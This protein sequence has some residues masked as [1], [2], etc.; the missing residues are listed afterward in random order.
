MSQGMIGDAGGSYYAEVSGTSGSTISIDL[1]S[2]NANTG[3]E[4]CGVLVTIQ[5]AFNGNGGCIPSMLVYGGTT[6]GFNGDGLMICRSSVRASGQNESGGTGAEQFDLS[7]TNV[8]SLGFFSYVFIGGLKFGFKSAT[9][10]S[11][12]TSAFTTSSTK[13]HMCGVANTTQNQNPYSITTQPSKIK[14]QT[15][16]SVAFSNFVVTSYGWGNGN[17]A[18]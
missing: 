12:F 10:I 3:E 1:P 2:N 8:G 14:F 4:N 6:G 7:S 17:K 5:T 13:L 18:S 9:S 11:T 15:N 16:N